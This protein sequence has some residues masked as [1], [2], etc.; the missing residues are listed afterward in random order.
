[1]LAVEAFGIL[2]GESNMR[3]TISR[4]CR[5][6]TVA[7]T[8]QYQYCHRLVLCNITV[9]PNDMNTLSDTYTSCR[10]SSA[11]EFTFKRVV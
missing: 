9:S 1:M 7:S 8:V 11:V 2:N 10:L 3:Y 5:S 4:A 6:L